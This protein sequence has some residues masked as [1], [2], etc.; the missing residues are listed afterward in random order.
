MSNEHFEFGFTTISPG[1]EHEMR[2][3]QPGTTQIKCFLRKPPPPGFKPCYA[4]GSF[5]V[6]AGESFPIYADPMLFSGTQGEIHVEFQSQ[7]TGNA[8]TYVFEVA[9]QGNSGTQ[10]V[11][12]ERF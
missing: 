8:N 3:K 6:S 7:V 9:D 2:A 5:T 4:C 12:Y 1:V 11:E 10:R